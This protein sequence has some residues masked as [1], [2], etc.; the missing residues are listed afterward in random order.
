MRSL[1]A[2]TVALISV[3]L[4]LAGLAYSQGSGT[5][6]LTG[7]IYDVSG[8]IIPNA[9]VKLTLESTGV[10][11]ETTTNSSGFFSFVGLSAGTYELTADA[12]GFAPYRQEGIV[13]HIND[14][15]D[16]KQV[17]LKVAGSTATV[18]VSGAAK[19]KSCPSPPAMCPTP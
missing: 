14:Q 13:L 12:A 3:A 15:I 7:T 8:A 6:T 11:R 9:K 10:G 17:Q 18:E 4:V 16:L 2:K 19:P 1:F 5:C